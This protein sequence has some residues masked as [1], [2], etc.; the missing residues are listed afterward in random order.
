MHKLYLL[1]FIYLIILNIYIKILNNI[2][3]KKILYEIELK[4]KLSK[5]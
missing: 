3:K 5:K 4:K 1:I 2:L